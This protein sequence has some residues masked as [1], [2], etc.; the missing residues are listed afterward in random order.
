[1]LLRKKMKCEGRLIIEHRCLEWKKGMKKPE[2]ITDK[3]DFGRQKC[4][5]CRKPVGGRLEFT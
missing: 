3:K 4:S 5:L 1:M 2:I